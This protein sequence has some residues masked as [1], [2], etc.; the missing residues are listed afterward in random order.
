MT[1]IFCSAWILLSTYQMPTCLHDENQQYGCFAYLLP[2]ENV[3]F[4]EAFLQNMNF[5]FVQQNSKKLHFVLKTI[6]WTFWLSDIRNRW[7]RPH[8]ASSA[9]LIKDIKCI[10]KIP[11]KHIFKI[12]GKI[13]KNT[14]RNTGLS[15]VRLELL[16]LINPLRIDTHVSYFHHTVWQQHSFGISGNFVKFYYWY[17]WKFYS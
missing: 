17:F 14:R 12:L 10:G 2:H 16:L 13:F 3:L 5:K 7:L 8:I 9:Q 15:W 4:S 6:F 11:A 1:K